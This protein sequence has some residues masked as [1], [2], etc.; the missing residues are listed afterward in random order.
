MAS[1]QRIMEHSRM[2]ASINGERLYKP[3]KTVILL[4]ENPKTRPLISGNP[5]H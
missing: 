1:V 3:Q 4:V 2:V 5:I